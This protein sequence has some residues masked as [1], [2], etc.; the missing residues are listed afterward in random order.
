VV[1]TLPS[2]KGAWD[3]AA[4]RATEWRDWAS[5]LLRLTGA[6]GRPDDGASRD[7]DDSSLRSRIQARV[8]A[9]KQQRDELAARRAAPPAAPAGAA[10]GA[11]GVRAAARADVDRALR[12]HGEM[13]TELDLARARLADAELKLRLRGL[14]GDGRLREQVAALESAGAALQDDVKRLDGDCQA[15]REEA[16]ALRAEAAESARQGREEASR[17]AALEDGL[18][19]CRSELEQQRE[20]RIEATRQLEACRAEAHRLTAAEAAARSESAGDQQRRTA[21]QEAMAAMR[22]DLQE[23]RS[24]AAETARRAE[25]LEEAGS[26]SQQRLTAEQ[27]AHRATRAK[28]LA[29]TS[30]LRSSTRLCSSTE[31]R[32][33]AAEGAVARLEQEA[34]ERAKEM[35]AAKQR[36]SEAEARAEY[37]RAAS[38]RE[39]ETR[40]QLIDDAKADI[41]RRATG[42]VLR[43]VVVAPTVRVQ[44]PPDEPTAVRPRMPLETLK[45]VLREEILPPFVRIFSRDTSGPEAGRAKGRGKV[46]AQEEWLKALVE[47]LEAGI[48]AQ[49]RETFAAVRTERADG[50]VLPA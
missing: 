6:S 48:E 19:A 34:A 13:E 9:V 2:S 46:Q 1:G 30:E 32:A 18:V 17:A 26:T 14:S 40:Q 5:G 10:S 42:K 16:A 47:D 25:M 45:A 43:L 35:G 12:E 24:G 39:R 49:L 15:L 28:L 22:R 41:A 50:V 20:A 36:A 3:S 29:V 23:A 27:T 11:G 44:V 4:P 37:L 21:A 33:A 8:E 31:G 7:E 38:V